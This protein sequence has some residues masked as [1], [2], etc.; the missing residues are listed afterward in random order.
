MTSPLPETASENMRL[1]LDIW[2]KQ[3]EIGSQLGVITEQLKAIPDHEQRLRALERWRYSL[4]LAA[5]GALVS[6][7]FA[8]AGYLHH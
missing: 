1:L 7:G 6:A 4:P 8:L 3:V 5:L 2:T